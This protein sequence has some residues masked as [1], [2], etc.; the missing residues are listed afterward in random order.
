MAKRWDYLD[1]LSEAENALAVELR[2][3]PQSIVAMIDLAYI[4]K[5]R[6]KFEQPTM[7]ETPQRRN[8]WQCRRH[9]S[10]RG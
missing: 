6:R 3:H 2:N 8:N 1:R 10:V 5:M 7:T 9:A 4:R